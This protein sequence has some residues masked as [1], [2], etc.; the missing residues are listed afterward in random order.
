MADPEEAV[1]AGIAANAF[2]VVE[3]T[4]D[5]FERSF[6]R[7]SLLIPDDAERYRETVEAGAWIS[8]RRNIDEAVRM[9]QR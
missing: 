6:R 3:A 5:E 4:A 2:I 9:A 7:L 8:D 1:T